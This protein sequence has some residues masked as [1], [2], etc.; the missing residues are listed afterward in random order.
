MDAPTDQIRFR[1]C[2][3][4]F[5][6]GIQQI[7]CFLEYCLLSVEDVISG[8]I[9]TNDKITFY[10][11][12]GDYTAKASLIFSAAMLILAC[13]KRKTPEEEMAQKQTG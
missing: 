1:E 9:N 13:I 2:G 7:A 6:G 5:D 3:I 11:R 12:Y 10:A 8:T 4:E